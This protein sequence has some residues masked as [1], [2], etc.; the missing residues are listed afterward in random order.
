MQQEVERLGLGSYNLVPGGGTS[1]GG[2]W[3]YFILVALLLFFAV[4]LTYLGFKL[5]LWGDLLRAVGAVVLAGCVAA[6]WGIGLLGEK[7]LLVPILVGAGAY[8][9]GVA[10][11]MTFGADTYKRFRA[12]PLWKRYLGRVEG[13]EPA[14]ASFSFWRMLLPGL[15]MLCG[16]AIWAGLSPHRHQAG[17]GVL[18]F[19]GLLVAI[20]SILIRRSPGGSE[21]TTSDSVPSTG[22]NE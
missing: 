21:P 19:V 13:I 22:P 7:E 15:A 1:M 5:H 6:I 2:D 9:V 12:L 4:R 18:M 3:R 10:M 16:G 11:D 20:F 14:P 8:W 17:W